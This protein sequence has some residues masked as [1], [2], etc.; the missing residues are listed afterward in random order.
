M[1]F[2]RAVLAI[3]LPLLLPLPAA[4]AGTAKEYRGTHVVDDYAPTLVEIAI[5]RYG[6]PGMWRDI[7][8]WNRIKR[9]YTVWIGRPLKLHRRPALSIKEGRTLILQMWRRKFD[10]IAESPEKLQVVEAETR[11]EAFK[12][13]VQEIVAAEAVAEE[14][15]SAEKLFR[16]GERL[17]NERKY[18]EALDHFRRSREADSDFLP[19]WMFSIRTLKML[20][21]E[22]EEAKVT[23]AFLDRHPRF[24]MLPMF[25]KRP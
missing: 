9:P 7:A 11:K 1:G 21:R 18:D 6:R 25:Q 13:E 2:R 8:R 23:E 4:A 19:P 3:L 20:K 15:P 5:L 17:F 12:K 10:T 24:K 22:D 16:D 14:A